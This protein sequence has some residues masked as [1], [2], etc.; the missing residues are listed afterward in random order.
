MKLST[1]VAA[2][3]LSSVIGIASVAQAA[4]TH[5]GTKIAAAQKPHKKHAKHAAKKHKKH[6]ASAAAK[7]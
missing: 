5:S 1:I 2:C 7:A 6:K 3:V 4:P